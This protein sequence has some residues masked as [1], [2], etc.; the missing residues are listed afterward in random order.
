M[1]PLVSHSDPHLKSSAILLAGIWRVDQLQDQVL[2]TAQNNKLPDPVRAA[3]L[4][5]T[6]QMRPRESRDLLG[7]V[8][9][10]DDSLGL[11]AA[12][13]Q[14]LATIDMQAA[15]PHAA[16]LLADRKLPPQDAAATLLAFLK[17]VGGASML[18][19]AL[20]SKSLDAESARNLLRSLFSTGRSDK[21]LFETFNQALGSVAEPPPYSDD[22]V[23]QLVAAAAD[24]GARDHAARDRGERL[25]DALACTSCHRISGKGGDLGPDLTAIGTTLSPDR[26]VEELLWPNRQVKEGFSIVQAITIEGKIVHGYQRVARESQQSGDLVLED[27]V[28][29]QPTTIAKQH[30]DELQI[31]GSSMPTGLTALLT[32]S[33]LLDLIQFLSELG[34]IDLSRRR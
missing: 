20:Q 6:T 23:Q 2:A 27:L 9:T 24:H 12:A 14:L 31:I 34:R 3:A 26:I 15:A 29:R 32:E 5:A 17:R 10:G 33:Q 8:A 19:S 16:D 28:T 4:E 22:Y 30:I 11:R 18:A 13:I 1:K 21:V 7:A 25:F